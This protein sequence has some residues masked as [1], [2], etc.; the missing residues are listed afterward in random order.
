MATTNDIKLDETVLRNIVRNTIK[1]ALEE[2]FEVLKNNEA[3]DVCRRLYKSYL[4][5]KQYN[6]KLAKSKRKEIITIKDSYLPK[7][8]NSVAASI[9]INVELNDPI[10]EVKYNG[11]LDPNR[12]MI[13][14][15]FNEF[16]MRD[17]ET[18]RNV[19]F[20]ELTHLLDNQHYRN[21]TG[22]Y[23]WGLYNDLRGNTNNPI[24]NI[25]YRLWTPTERNAYTTYA[26]SKNLDFLNDYIKT[27]EK[28]INL[29]DQQPLNYAKPPF[30]L[31]VAKILLNKKYNN[32]E[33]WVL[34]KDNFVKKSRML[35]DR[36]KKK[37]YQRFGQH[38]D[39]YQV[40]QPDMRDVKFQANNYNMID[41]LSDSF[42]F[43]LFKLIKSDGDFKDW[44]AI[45]KQENPR[46]TNKLL[47]F[48]WDREFPKMLKVFMDDP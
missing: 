22:F 32:T 17:Y 24:A 3:E 21:E 31:H 8:N 12:N 34:A 25:I 46:L 4:I 41:K 47:K 16:A 42:M 30:W 20:H 7:D 40:Y 36:F 33:Q 38:H 26:Y 15:T 5:K 13:F 29:L 1:E 6:E 18:F 45:K 39:D 35:L 44:V 37:A 10:Q 14:L 27:L 43:D 19:V 28:Q 48:I 23:H 11:H 9:S 2:K